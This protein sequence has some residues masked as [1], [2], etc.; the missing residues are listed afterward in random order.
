[1]IT[2]AC[3]ALSVPGPPGQ[4]K[5]TVTSLTALNVSW[6]VPQ[7][8]NGIIRSYRVVYYQEDFVDGVYSGCPF[9]IRGLP[10]L[11]YSFF[12]L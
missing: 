3:S 4:L 9:C 8:T 12:T 5:F 6:L 11:C 7:E 10:I 2:H 1:M